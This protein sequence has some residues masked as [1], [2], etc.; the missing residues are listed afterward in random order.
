MLYR[1]WLLAGEAYGQY[2]LLQKS[3]THVGGGVETP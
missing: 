2:I 1:W 3:K